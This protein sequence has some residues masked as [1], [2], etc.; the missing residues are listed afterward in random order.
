MTEPLKVTHSDHV[1]TFTLN[2]PDSRNPISDDEM[3]SAIVDACDAVNR[4]RNVRAV[5]ITGAGKAFSAGGN[6]RDM[7]DR[8]G[9]FAG[10]SAELVSDVSARGERF[11]GA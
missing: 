10:G 4:D 1:R 9:M 2:R 11:S 5:V 3:V 6:V 7:R 8:S